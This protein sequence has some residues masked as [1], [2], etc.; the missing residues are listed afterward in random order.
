[1]RIPTDLRV[2]S[3][4]EREL[5]IGYRPCVLARLRFS[6]KVDSSLPSLTPSP[7]KHSLTESLPTTGIYLKFI[8][9]LAY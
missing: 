7:S 9:F 3:I 6:S 5:I 2:T 1:M 8:L 4:G